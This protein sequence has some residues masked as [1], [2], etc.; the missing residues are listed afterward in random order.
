MKTNRSNVAYQLLIVAMGIIALVLM[1]N[2]AQAQ[3]TFVG[4]APLIAQTA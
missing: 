1:I 3:S 4:G 2:I